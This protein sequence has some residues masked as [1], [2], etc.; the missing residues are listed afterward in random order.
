VRIE[1]RDDRFENIERIRYRA[2]NMDLPTLHGQDL[3]SALRRRTTEPNRSSI[4]DP[5]PAK[6][7]F[8]RDKVVFFVRL[9]TINGFEEEWIY[10]SI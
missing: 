4:E 3:R 5:I 9:V 7:T 2:R 10:E 6:E 1:D 8:N